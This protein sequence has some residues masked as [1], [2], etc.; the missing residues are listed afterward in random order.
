[1]GST[2]SWPPI[3]LASALDVRRLRV[4]GLR[5]LYR[6]AYRLV[7][8]RMVLLPGRGRGVKCV[9]TY[10]DEVLLV[11]HTYGARLKWQLPGG[12]AHRG[13]DPRHVAAREMREELGLSELSWRELSTLD[14]RLEHIAV[15]LT[16][17]HAEL[18][19]P[20]VHPDPV[21]IAQAQ[22]FALDELPPLLGSEVE[23]LLDLLFDPVP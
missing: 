1:V 6:V 17:M 7:Q 21:E 14:M 19:S 23:Q 10:G 16:C 13:E 11:R 5:G 22:W 2:V 3:R 15:N 18:K 4:A 12:A 8:L 20:A 9:L